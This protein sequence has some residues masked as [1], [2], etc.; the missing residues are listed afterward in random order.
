MAST[1]NEQLESRILLLDGGFGT[2]VQQYGLT[3]ED[4]RGERFAEWPLRLRG[5]ND[6]LALTQPDTVRAIHEKYLAAGSDIITTDSFNANAVSL[7][8]YG[9]EGNAHQNARAA[10]ET[11]RREA[12]KDWKHTP[13]RL[14]ARQPKRRVGRPTHARPAI[15]RNLASWGARSARR[16]MRCR[17][18]RRWTTLRPAT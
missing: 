9:L 18:R 6:L 17:S 1:L 7:R 14:R 15:R 12:T 8:D 4:Y 5:C 11:A 16:T 2:M 13:T 3:E 10:G